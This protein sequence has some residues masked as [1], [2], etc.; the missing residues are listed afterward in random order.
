M[1]R[2]FELVRH[3]DGLG[4]SGAGHVT[5]GGIWPAIAPYDVPQ[6]RDDL[7]LILD[8]A[9]EHAGTGFGSPREAAKIQR[10][11]ARLRQVL[12]MEVS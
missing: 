3:T 8:T 2:Q 6:T 4:V 7:A 10:A 5:D 1:T 11:A 12:Q 9:E